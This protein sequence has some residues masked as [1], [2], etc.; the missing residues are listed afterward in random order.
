MRK[1]QTFQPDGLWLV[2]GAAVLWG[3]IGVATQAIYNLDTTTSLFINLSRMLIATPVLLAACWHVVGQKMFRIQ[4]RDFLIMLLTGNLLAIS[5]ASYFVAIHYTGVTIATLLTICIAPVVVTCLSVALKFETLT[6]RIVIA[7]VCAVVGSILLV[8]LHAPEGTHYQLLLGAVFSVVAAV[9]YAGMIICGRFLA[10]VY[11][12]LQV[13]SVTFGA[14]TLLLVL[15]NVASGMVVVHTAQ[16]WLLVLYLGLVPTA[17]AYWL[18]QMG[19][20]S[21]S[22]TAASIVSL[23]EPVVAAILAWVLFG[24]TLAGTGI[25]GAALLIVSIF[26]LSVD[27]RQ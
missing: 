6:G 2:T 3:T 8:G 27:K 19:L 12:P 17:C 11:H 1:L 15:I 4:R 14:G 10:S 25:I 13:M 5:Q 9:S 18:F 21:V 20:R 23:L 16:G 7:L 26:L 22:A 24:E